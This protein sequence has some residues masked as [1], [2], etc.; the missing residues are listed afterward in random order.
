MGK[1]T[2]DPKHW[3]KRAEE[4]RRLADE[5]SDEK[6]RLKMVEIADGYELLA[7]RAEERRQR[8]R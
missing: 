2:D 1:P 3:R 8:R 6:M 5:A 4:M 7:Q